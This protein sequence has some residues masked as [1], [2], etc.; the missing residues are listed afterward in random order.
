[1]KNATS[2]PFAPRPKPPV[3]SEELRIEK[4]LSGEGLYLNHY[5]GSDCYPYKVVEVSSSGKTVLAKKMNARRKEGSEPYSQCWEYSDSEGSPL[6]KFT[7][8]KS[9]VFK[10]VGEHYSYA[11]PSWSPSY[12]YDY[13]F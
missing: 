10:P 13:S 12:H 6:K 1:M 8:R 3:L 2:N 4:S 11:Y 9:G 5:I 7:Q